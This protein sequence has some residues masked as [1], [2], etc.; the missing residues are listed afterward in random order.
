MTEITEGVGEGLHAL[1]VFING[2]VT[3]RHGV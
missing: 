3:L 1:A 2:G